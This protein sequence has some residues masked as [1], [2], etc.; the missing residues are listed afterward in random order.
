MCKGSVSPVQ[1]QERESVDDGDE[2]AAP[3]RDLLV[4]KQVDGDGGAD[5][6]LDVRPDDGRLDHQPQHDAGILGI[7]LEAH[8]H[9]GND[10]NWE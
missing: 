9:N 2:G 8:L 10:R 1:Q 7:V 4:T 5:H 3:Q 6:L